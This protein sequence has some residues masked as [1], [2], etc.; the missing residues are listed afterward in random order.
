MA[1]SAK[2]LARHPRPLGGD[3]VKRLEKPIVSLTNL[4]LNNQSEPGGTSHLAAKRKPAWLR[5]KLPG[6]PGY[7]RLNAILTEHRLHTVCKEAGCPNMG[8]CWSRGVATIMILGDT[9][10]RSCGFCN[11]K[12]GKPPIL[13]TDEPYRVA[14]SLQLMGLKH[15]VITSVNRDELADGGAA[16]WAKTII[17]TRKTCPTMSI[18]VLI[19]DFEG[20]WD[21]LQLVIEAR[22]EILN[23]NLET[24]RRMYPAV[25]PQAKFDRS[26]ELL[27]RCKDE[28][29]VTK[30]GIMV[31]I[32]EKDAEVLELMADI[33]SRAN[34]DILTIGQYLQPTPNH[35]PIDRW[36]HPDTFA[37]YREE[38]L[39]LGFKVI[40]SG[41]L[42]RSSYHADDQADRLTGAARETAEGMERLITGARWS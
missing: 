38:G 40:E 12:T 1:I 21:A 24:V 8:E 27:K 10:T 18:E 17:E 6:G 34:I 42:V 11:V 3:P 19:P 2:A 33:R 28:G 25:R 31:G 23:H 36:V 16:I 7:E 15:V 26:V 20:N 13:D 37:M 41:P 4:V 30:T 14:Q 5:A 39:K 9:C 29:L 32:G 22:P 35:L